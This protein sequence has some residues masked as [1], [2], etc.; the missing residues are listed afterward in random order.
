[1]TR[2]IAVCVAAVTVAC[3]GSSNDAFARKL[4]QAASWAAAAEFAGSMRK[5]GRVPQAYIEDLIDHGRE[6]VAGLEK[7][8]SSDEHV[9]PPTRSRASALCGRL[10]NA[11][12]QSTQDGGLDVND[13]RNIG[14]ELRDLSAAV[15]SAT[16]GTA[17]GGLR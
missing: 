16:A 7:Q 5:A 10:A 4:D 1:M 12:R 15:R 3:T 2:L 8:L 11:F 13:L 9:P 14:A 17:A 6:E